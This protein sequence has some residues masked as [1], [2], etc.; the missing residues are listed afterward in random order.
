MPTL[1]P[2]TERTLPHVL[3]RWARETPDRIALSDSTT[4]CTYAQ[5]HERA[6]AVGGGLRAITPDGNGRVLLLLDNHADMALAWAGT[7]LAGLVEIPVNTAYRGDVLVH[8]FNDSQA[9]TAVVDEPYLDRIAQVADEL[10]YLRHIVVRGTPTAARIGSIELSNYQDLPNREQVEL[11]PVQ[12][13]DP[14]A[15]MYTSGTTGVSK[16][17]LVSHAHAYTYGSPQL[18]GGADQDDTELVV[19]PLFHV[20]GQWAGLFNAWIAGARA[21]V[22]DRFDGAGFWDQARRHHCTYALIV[23]TMAN[24]LM[25]QPERPDDADNP[26]RRLFIAPVPEGIEGFAKRFDIEVSTGYGSTE[27][28]TVLVAPAGQARAHACGQPAPTVEVRVVDDTDMDVPAGQVGEL[29]V[30]PREPWITMLEYVGRSEATVET[31]RNLWYH[32]GDAVYRDDDGQYV[33]VDRLGDAVRRRGEN[34]PSAAVEA[35]INAHP[36]VLECAVVGVP[37]DIEHEVLAV[38]VP[39]PGIT[40]DPADLLRT[41]VDRLPHFMVPRYIR[42][43]DQLERTPSGKVRKRPLREVGLTPDT[44]DRE[45]A[46]IAVTRRG[47]EERVPHG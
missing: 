24:F 4:T 17:V 20:G 47:L 11:P 15:I 38:V 32:T 5:L 37:G 1:P 36:S 43:V 26:F 2:L 6:R 46:G 29:V 39:H 18:L 12:A 44:W 22:A 41:L 23:G 42:I 28:G 10:H 40:L 34:I 33:F 35:A 7:A 3:E 45:A 30:R 31:W 8:Q 25:Q 27:A 13:S 19:L 14:M 16:G 9:S 21:H